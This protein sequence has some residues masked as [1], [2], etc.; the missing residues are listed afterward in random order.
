MT[1]HKKGPSSPAVSAIIAARNAQETIEASLLSL[2]NQSHPPDEILVVTNG[3]TDSTIPLVENLSKHHPSIRRLDSPGEQ[4]VSGALKRACQEARFPLLARM[5]ADDL[6]HPCRLAHQ[7]ET[8]LSNHADL[9]TCSV[10]PRNSLGPGL[11]RYIQWTNSLRTPADFLR[12]R[13]IESPV[14]QPGVLMTKHAYQA[15]GGYRVETGPEDYDLWLRMLALNQ[16]FFQSPQAQLQWTDS[17]NRLTRTHDDY[18]ES[19]IAATKARHLA[20]LPQ[21]KTHGIT[22]AGSGPQGR[23][24]ARLLLSFQITIH[25]FF[26]VDPKKIGRTHRNIPIL[27]PHDFGSAHRQ[28]ILLGTVGHNGRHRVRTLANQSGYLEGLNYFATC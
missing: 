1:P 28:A 15:A 4:G 2:L 21:I 14:I 16:R 23:R 27:G 22:I 11:D 19:N 6:A 13:F 12:E 5:D 20:Q 3:C 9:V 8:L 24:L 7:L 10:K 18:S 17:P 26:D 25:A